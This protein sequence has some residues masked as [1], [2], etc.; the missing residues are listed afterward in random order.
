MPWYG[1]TTLEL[2][3]PNDWDVNVCG[4]GGEGT[5]DWIEPKFDGEIPKDKHGEEIGRYDAFAEF[6]EALQK[7]GET[8]STDISD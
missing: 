1:D 3:L 5:L 4:M 8:Y 7:N 2:E 6:R